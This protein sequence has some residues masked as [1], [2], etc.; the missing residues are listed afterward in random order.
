MLNITNL[1]AGYNGK[2]V[3]DVPNLSLGS[4]EHCLILGKSG[5]GKTTLLYAIAGLLKP[6]AGEI[7]LSDVNIVAISGAALDAFRGKN[8]GIIYQTL[9]M[10]SALSVLDNSE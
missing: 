6:M 3:V 7:T 10:V 5:S 8:I 4:G 9:H 2:A 1:K